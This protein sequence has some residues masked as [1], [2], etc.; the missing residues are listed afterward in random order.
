MMWGASETAY[1]LYTNENNMDEEK[2]KIFMAVHYKLRKTWMK[3]Q[4]EKPGSKIGI[5]SGKPWPFWLYMRQYKCIKYRCIKIH[6]YNDNVTEKI[7]NA[8]NQKSLIKSKMYIIKMR[9]TKF[10]LDIFVYFE[11]ISEAKLIYFKLN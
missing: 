2:G 10:T 5:S 3:N 11:N 1:N 9:K 4:R 8:Y 6:E 7:P